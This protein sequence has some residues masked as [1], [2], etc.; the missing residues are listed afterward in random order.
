[1]VLGRAIYDSNGPMI[2]GSGTALPENFQITL[3]VYGVR[4]LLIEDAR[5]ANIPVLSLYAPELEAEAAQS[6]RQLISESQGS[7]RVDDSLLRPG[8]QAAFTMTRYLFPRPSGQVDVAGCHLV[9]DYNFVQPVKVAGRS[10]FLGKLTRYGMLQ[11][12]SLG[13]A[14]LF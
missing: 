6:L 9:E 13:T 12:P 2:L 5:V 4:D 1:M 3:A 7:T 11:L 14:A 8:D 10:L